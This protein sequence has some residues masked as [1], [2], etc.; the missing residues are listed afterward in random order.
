MDVYHQEPLP[1][2]H[3]LL[4]LDNVLL[5]PHVAF[6]TPEATDALL[7]ISIDNIVGYYRGDP[8]NVVAAPE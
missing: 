6:N 4:G 3:P 5:S 1:R 7:D 2:D 8:V